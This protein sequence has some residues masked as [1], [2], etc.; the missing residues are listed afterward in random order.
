MPANSRRVTPVTA[1]RERWVVLGRRLEARRRWLGHTYRSTFQR[2]RGINTRLSADIEKAAK[3]RV[4][5]FMPATMELIAMGY[6]VTEESMYAVLR[7]ESAELVPADPAAPPLP[8]APA[9]PLPAGAQ[10]APWTEPEREAADHPYALAIFERL[11]ILSARGITDP[12]GAEVVLHRLDADHPP[13][14]S[15]ADAKSWDDM[16]TWPGLEYP[17]DLVW[18]LADVQRRAADRAGNPGTGTNGLVRAK[19]AG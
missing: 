18:V 15:P 17:R 3:D 5:H 1:P 10:D 7:N 6:A 11:A 8:Q 14:G 19:V 13:V 9:V 16:R 2:D 12:S 4:N